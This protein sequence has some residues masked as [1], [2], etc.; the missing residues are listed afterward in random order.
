MAKEVITRTARD[1]R[2]MHKDFHGALSAGLEYLESNFGEAAVREYLRQFASTFYAPL[3][4][5]LKQRGLVALQ[6]HF[7]S[8]YEEEGGKATITLD[9][10]E[11]RIEVEVCP[12]VSHMREH[13]YPVARLFYETTKTVNET[14]CEDTPYAAELV[15][16]DDQTGR[17]IQRFYRREQ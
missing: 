16:Y 1:N 2:Y 10:D 8:I 4:A 7:G 11:L 15:A 3:T 6:E 9:D 14:I 13:G 17:S 12:A 5:D